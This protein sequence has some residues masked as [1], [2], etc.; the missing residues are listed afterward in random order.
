MTDYDYDKST[1]FLG[2]WGSYQW[3]LL[4]LLSLTIV[5]NGFTGLSIVFLADT[6][7]HRCHIPAEANLS[8]AWMNSSIPLEVE[9]SRDSDAAVPSRCARYKLRVLREFSERGLEPEDVNVSRV[10][11]EPCLDGW[12]YDTSVYTSTIIT[13]WDLVCDD[14]WKNPLTTS[15]HYCGVLAGS[16]I[17][18][19]L[20]DRFGRKVVMFASIAITNVFCFLQIFSPSWPVFCALYFVIG[21]GKISS[22]VTA[23]V[24]GM[25][26]LSPRVRTAYSTAGVC[27]FFAAGYMLMPLA[28]FFLRDWKSLL[29]GLTLPSLALVPLWW[30]IPESP[31]W[32]LSQGRTEEAEL[33]IKNAAKINKKDIPEIIFKSLQAGPLSEKKNTSYN[34]C[35]LLRWGSLRWL[36]LTLWIIWNSVTIAYF[37]L[38]LNTSNLHGDV[39][40]NC[41]LSALVE[42]P[43]YVL[44]WVMFRW[45]PRRLCLSSSL[46]MCGGF[47]LLIPFI[48][49]NLTALAT[50]L[51]MLGKFG[52]TA[53]FTIVY[54][55]TAELYPTVL[56]NTAVATCSMAARL[57]S[58]IAPY[59]IYLRSLWVS[60]PYMLM[61][62]LTVVTGVMSLLLPE[63]HGLPLPETVG[64]M[65]PFPGCCVNKPYEP[66]GDK[67]EEEPIETKSSI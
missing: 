43:A 1:A 25:E 36:S 62:A 32:L 29:L 28:A 51:E 46:V 6:P 44:S 10:E 57:G 49:Q 59:F 11:T 60:L 3:R 58:I 12:E 66:T 40:F 20:A 2:E 54:A 19:Q 48:P 24:L 55:Y 23:F 30:Y 8:A 41:F 53:A 38:S 31:R 18:G 56:R 5:P 45:C 4:I 52:A 34:I 21:M 16:F 13:E 7:S 22:Y 14:S 27:L 15:I 9:Q 64:Q 17:S 33:V 42:V 67:E 65:Q 50:A 63:S 26:V 35:A 61:G 47:L 39:Y 37:A